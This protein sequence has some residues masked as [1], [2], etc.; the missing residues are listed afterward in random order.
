MTF[1]SFL[2]RFYTGLKTFFRH[3]FSLKRF[4][5]AASSKQLMSR[6]GHGGVLLKLAR[7]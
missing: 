5:K 7:Q 4:A 2:R 1:F 3:K 6:N